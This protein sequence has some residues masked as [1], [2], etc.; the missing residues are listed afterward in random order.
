MNILIVDDEAAERRNLENVLTNVR[1]NME[2]TGEIFS[3]ANAAETLQLVEK[4]RIDTAFLDIEMPGKDGLTLAKELLEK[5]PMMNIIMMTAYPEYALE[6]HKLYVSG[7]LLKPAMEDE[8]EEALRNLRH[9]VKDFRKGLYVRC[10]GNFEVFYNGEIV[11]FGR[12]Q[13]KEMLAYLIDRRGAGVTGEEL[14]AVLWE[15][16]AD[17]SDR[18]RD[19]LHKI[20]YD[21]RNTLTNLGCGDA[22]IHMRNTYAVDTSKIPCDYYE[23]LEKGGG[24]LVGYTGEYMTQYSWAEESDVPRDSER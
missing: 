6:A 8:V 12:R 22:I 17:Y 16:A 13:A 1:K 9:P 7:Y 14:R 19:Y 20:W 23:A 10:F 5:Y 11:K 15:D 24:V 21:L 2:G 3:A 4:E 18:Q